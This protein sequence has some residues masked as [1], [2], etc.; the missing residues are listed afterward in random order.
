MGMS[1]NEIEAM[2]LK[3]LPG[4]TLDLQ[5]LAGDNDHYSI[6]V[7]SEAFI[8]KSRVQQHKMVFDALGGGMGTRLHALSVTTKTPESV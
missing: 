1:A 6:V 4:A 5:D 3:A 7:T 8:G 2:V